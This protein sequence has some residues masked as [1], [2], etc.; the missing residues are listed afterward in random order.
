LENKGYTF[1]DFFSP[2]SFVPLRAGR[3]DAP[4]MSK[5][6]DETLRS[7]V[8]RSMKQSRDMFINSHGLRAEGY[9]PAKRAKIDIKTRTEYGMLDDIQAQD[10]TLALPDTKV[11]K[12][13]L[14]LGPATVAPLAL[15][16]PSGPTAAPA[17]V[18]APAPAAKLPPKTGGS[19]SVLPVP[20]ST[21]AAQQRARHKAP[22]W[23]A[24]WKLMK[25][26]AG[27][28][29]WVRTLAVD[30][31]NQWF[32]SAGDDRVIKVW[33]LASA[34]LK[35]TLTGHIN[36]IKGL[37]ISRTS[38]YLFSVAEDK[39][40]KCW[41][42]ETNQAIRHYHG[43]LSGVYSVAIHPALDILFSGGRDGTVRVWDMR[44]KNQVHCLAGHSHTVHSVAVQSAQPQV[45]SGSQDCTVRLWDLVKGASMKTLTNHKKGVR[46]LLIHP[47]E[48]TFAS[49]SAD[50][51]KKWKCPDGDFV[52]NFRGHETIVHCLAVN[53]DGVLVS[54]GDNGTIKMWDWAS[55]HL[56]QDM[57]T[58]AQPGSL[59]AESAVFAATFDHSGTRLLTGEADKTIKIWRED[60]AATP[61]THPVRFNPDLVPKR[62]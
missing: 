33:D 6:K 48:Y 25:V 30:H 58:I 32:A 62:Y 38:P 57:D 28:T 46:A 35:L 50:N 23:H 42:L 39:T 20:P 9:E 59:E 18:A 12:A 5:R 2:P 36:A 56:F 37:A 19:L 31:T 49:A 41:D 21:L 14:I 1:E 11:S 60:P 27:H 54:G 44:T 61:E 17:P 4:L 34:Q 51:I 13:K 45:I 15:P 47:S 29:G 16:A 8:A 7:V 40:V 3:R 43:H 24:P 55:G 53:E 22:K 10:P 52:E 26:I